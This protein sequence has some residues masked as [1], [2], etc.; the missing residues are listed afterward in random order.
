MRK[1]SWIFVTMIALVMAVTSFAAP[2]KAAAPA[3]TP[4]AAAPAGSTSSPQA[5]TTLLDLN[6]ATMDQLKALP[7]IGDAYS[8]KIVA[9]R[10]YKAKSELVSKKIIP[11]AVYLKIKGK[12]IAKQ[13]K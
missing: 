6:T 13:T 3:S 10:P 2:K 4:A 8:A 7:G 12:V 11:N 1:Y 9:G 5:A